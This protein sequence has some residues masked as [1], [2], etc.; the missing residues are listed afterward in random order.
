MSAQKEVVARGDTQ[1][2]QEE[3]AKIVKKDLVVKESH[4]S[5]DLL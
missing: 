1:E 3:D 4:V 5:I 2:T